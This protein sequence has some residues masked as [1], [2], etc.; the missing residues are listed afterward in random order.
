[1]DFTAAGAGL[2]WP[3]NGLTLIEIMIVVV[4]LGALA[5]LVVPNMMGKAGEARKTGWR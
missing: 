4:I 3:V 2:G 1:M 5:A